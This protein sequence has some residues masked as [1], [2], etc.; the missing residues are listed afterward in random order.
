MEY[1]TRDGQSND[2][3]IT[4]HLVTG[5]VV[6]YAA[7]PVLNSDNGHY[8]A[9]VEHYRISRIEAKDAAENS[10]YNGGHGQLVTITSSNKM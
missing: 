8:Y 1:R 6:E 5:Y 2:N 10:T 7:P 9:Y 4:S 3:L